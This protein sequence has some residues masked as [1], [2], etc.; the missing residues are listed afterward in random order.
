MNNV[1]VSIIIP[2]YNMEKYI[3]RT[4]ETLINQTTKMNYEIIVIN[5]GS[6]DNSLDIIKKYEEKYSKKILVYNKENGGLSDA[7]NFGV[8]KANGKYICFVDAGDYISYNLLEKLEKYIYKN[9]DIIKYK[10]VKVDENGNELS[11]IE[12]PVFDINNGME[13]LKKLIGNDFY[14][15]VACIYLYKK[16]FWDKYILNL[17]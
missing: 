13:A 4:L 16:E 10:L 5:D 2:V 12:G 9:I 11:K 15:E 14:L 7:R 6:T 17:H 1:L 8:S 3:D